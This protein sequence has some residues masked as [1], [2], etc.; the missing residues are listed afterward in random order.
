MGIIDYSLEPRSDIAFI[1][2]KSFYAS[3]ECVAMGRHP[4]K[5]SLCVMSRS[6]NSKGLILAASPTFKRVFGQNNIGRAYDLPFRVEDRRFNFQRAHRLGLAVTDDYVHFIEDW[7]R[8]TEIVPPRMSYYI[9][10]N[11]QIQEIL[12]HYAPKEEIVPYSIDEAFIDL[13]RSLNYLAGEYKGRQKQL[14]V[15]SQRI[16]EEILNET[17][18]YSTIGMSNANP[19]LAKLAL[20]IEAKKNKNMRANWSYEDV[21]SKVWQIEKLTD[22]WGIGKRMA[23]RLNRLKIYSIYDLAHA[24]PQILKDEL[25]V[26]GLQ[27]W[28]HA[29]GVD[30]SDVRYPYRPKSTGLGNSQILPRDYYHQADIE[31]VLSEMAEQ[32]AIRLRRSHQK[33]SCVAI[34]IGFSKTCSKQPIIAQKSIEA[35]QRTK[36]LRQHVLDLFRR[37]YQGGPVRNIGVRYSQMSDDT[38]QTISL[39]DDYEASIKMEKLENAIDEIR[40]KHGFL[41][42]QPATILKDHSR[43]L[44]RSRLIGGHAAGGA[45]GLDGL[46]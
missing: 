46:S 2:M 6:D 21:E 44:A 40:S 39:F 32:V 35:T 20:D 45:G 36:V 8:K 38:Y 4:L 26:I 19:L 30:E 11:M 27:L 24:N 16:Q 31:L 17:G 42:V 1:D 9:Q 43:T 25:G 23:K 15:V 12:T 18:I 37:K 3:V 5:T 13:T 14:D 33:A 41:A 28:F 22:F 7:A 10:V 29:N 34:Y